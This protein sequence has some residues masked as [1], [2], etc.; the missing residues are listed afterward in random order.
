MGQGARVRGIEDPERT[1]FLAALERGEV[2][3]QM[4]LSKRISVSIGL[5]DALLRRTI[6]KGFVKTKAAPHKG[7]AYYLTPKGFS[8]KSR[9]VARYLRGL[10]GS[11]RHWAAGIR[12]VSI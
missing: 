6:H 11:G 1:D 7:Y 2:V 3:A 10:P 8:E 12:V 5:I 4:T 9:L